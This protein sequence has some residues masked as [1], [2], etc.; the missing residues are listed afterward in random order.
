MSD[1]SFWRHRTESLQQYFDRQRGLIRARPTLYKG[2]QFRSGLEA[3]FAWHLDD[4]GEEWVYEPRVYGRRGKRYLP[5]FEIV[6]STYPTFIELKPTLAE[7]D[8]AKA[9]MSVIWD[10]EPTALLI[11]ACWEGCTFTR[12]FQHGDWVTWQERWAA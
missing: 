2:I 1:T 5:D 11:V 7:V 3:R 10:S 8:G 12:A 9:K 4:R 6:G